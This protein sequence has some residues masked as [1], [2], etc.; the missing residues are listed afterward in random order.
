MG[1]KV[2]NPG[3]MIPNSNT[4]RPLAGTGAMRMVK[5]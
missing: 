2:V 3:K 5:Y 4:V 1:R